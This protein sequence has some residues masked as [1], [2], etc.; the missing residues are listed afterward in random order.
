MHDR[1]LEILLSFAG[2]APDFFE[3]LFI[4]SMGTVV[5]AN[6]SILIGH[7]ARGNDLGDP[8]I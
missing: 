1:K 8:K 5:Y 4:G 7:C 6:V 2:L 3:H